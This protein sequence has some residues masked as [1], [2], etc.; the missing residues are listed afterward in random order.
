[1]VSLT[2]SSAGST[3]PLGHPATTPGYSDLLPSI[4]DLFISLDIIGAADVARLGPKAAN[5]ALLRKAGLPVPP[6][7]CVPVSVHEHYI[8]HGNMPADLVDGIIKAKDV[9]GGKIALR[10]SATCEDGSQLSMAGVFETFY[11]RDDCQIADSV[12][13]IFDQAHSA[14]VDN[15]LKL[16]GK[17]AKEVR[18]GL[19]VQRLIEPELSGVI[20]TG[21]NGDNILV[22]YSDGFGADLVD[23][24]L[25]GSAFIADAGGHVIESVGFDVRP[26]SEHAIAQIRRHTRQIEKLFPDGPL[27]IEFTYCDGLVCIVQARPLTTRL[28]LIDLKEMPVDCLAFTKDSVRRLIARE[29]TDFQTSTA[30]FS[31]ANYSE[32]LPRPTEMDIGLYMYVWGGSDGVPGAKQIGHAQMGY[33]VRPEAAGI[34]SNVGGRTY[35]SIARYAAAYHMGF[36][37]TTNEY[38]KTL[39]EEYL[40]AIQADP[41]KGAYPQMGLFLQDPTLEDL[42]S[43]YGD[44]AEEYLQLYKHFM[45]RMHGFAQDFILDFTRRVPNATNA[46]DATGAPELADLSREQLLERAVEILEHIRTSSFVDFVKA[47]RLGFYYSNRLQQLLVEKLKYTK[48]QSEKAFSRLTQGLTG[49]AITDANLA[50]ADAGSDDEAM[51]LAPALIGHLSTGEMLEIRHRRMRDDHEALSTY[52]KGIRDAGNYRATFESQRAARL[53]AEKVTLVEL[54]AEDRGEFQDAMTASQTYMALRETVKY[55]FTKEYLSLRDALEVLAQKAGLGDGDIYFLY[56]RELARLVAAPSDLHHLI[57]A[58]RQSFQNYQELDMPHVIRE[59][60]LDAIKLVSDSDVDFSEAKG[61]FLADG[62]SVEG[63]IINLDEWQNLEDASELMR[64]YHMQN[65]AVVLVSTQMNLSHDPFIARAAGLVIENAGIVAH[66][67]QR[68]RELGK[69]AIGGIKAHQLKTG[70]K[71][72]F[73][74]QNQTL[75]RSS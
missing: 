56:P 59:S 5:L 20:Y 32:L 69:G 1:M 10:S 74:P 36:P 64:Q 35:S 67:A 13:H 66:G 18:M 68:A 7:Y 48:L 19:L 34:I 54:S 49:S 29:K 26:L 23:G 46:V 17:S 63:Q 33:L 50:L 24:T 38:F 14:D 30:I 3:L 45:T 37:E 55:L 71:V 16:H 44:R 6:A 65:I 31:D 25:R 47:A 61:K 53:E 8:R 72:F 40:A 42:R 4:S 73:D 39:V 62:P 11:I 52:V 22:Q 9:L 58:R 28:G 27:D 43:R 60:D 70:M 15:F 41:E 75:R 57:Q 2:S 51:R 12:R 21:V